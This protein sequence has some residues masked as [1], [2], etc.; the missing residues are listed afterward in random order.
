MLQRGAGNHSGF[1]SSIIEELIRMV[2]VLFVC[3]SN[4]CRSPMAEFVMKDLVRQN[5]L[6][7]QC[8]KK[9]TP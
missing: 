1:E 2:R 5:G 9:I 8:R 3:H 6:P 7:L 4:I